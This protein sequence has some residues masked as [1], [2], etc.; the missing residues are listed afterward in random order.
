MIICG[1]VVKECTYF[2]YFC[3]RVC[4]DKESHAVLNE[5]ILL[6][7]ISFTLSVIRNLS[8]SWYNE[9]P[10]LDLSGKINSISVSNLASA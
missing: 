3:L 1:A 7:P 6:Q 8:S 2:E 9:S 5:R 10:D 4:L